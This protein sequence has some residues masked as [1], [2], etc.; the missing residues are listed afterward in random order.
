MTLNLTG[1]KNENGE[2][3]SRKLPTTNVL[4]YVKEEIMPTVE[5]CERKFSD[6]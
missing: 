1:W 3:Q 2:P 4:S 5:G 6:K